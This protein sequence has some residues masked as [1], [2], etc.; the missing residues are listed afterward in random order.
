MTEPKGLVV[1]LSNKAAL[2]DV[3]TVQELSDI[4]V[5]HVA[6]AVDERCAVGHEVHIVTCEGELILHRCRPCDVHTC[7]TDAAAVRNLGKWIGYPLD[8]MIE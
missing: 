4:L 2:A 6:H 8:S 7:A 3:D 5:A 1:I